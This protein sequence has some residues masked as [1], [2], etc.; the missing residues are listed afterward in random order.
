MLMKYDEI[1][2]ENDDGPDQFETELRQL[3][4]R[5]FG[6]NKALGEFIISQPNVEIDAGAKRHMCK[7]KTFLQKFF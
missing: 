3:G 6:P 5:I 1:G 7:E 2:Q 4:E